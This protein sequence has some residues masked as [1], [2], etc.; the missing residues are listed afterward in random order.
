MT[1]YEEFM[2]EQDEAGTPYPYAVAGIGY[3]HEVLAIQ[4]AVESR[5]TGYYDYTGERIEYVLIRSV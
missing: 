4:A 2:A 1:S 5:S 3:D